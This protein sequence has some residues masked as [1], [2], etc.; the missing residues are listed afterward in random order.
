MLWEKI[1]YVCETAV[2]VDGDAAQFPEHWL[3]KHRWVRAI[4]PTYELSL[5]EANREK[6]RNETPTSFW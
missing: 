2:G 1:R 4:P 5:T 3:F 6:A